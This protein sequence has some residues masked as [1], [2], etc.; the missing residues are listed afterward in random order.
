MGPPPPNKNDL[1]IPLC[2]VNKNEGRAF[3][4][5]IPTLLGLII[6]GVYMGYPCPSFCWWA[7]FGRAMPDRRGLKTYSALAG[8][9]KDFGASLLATNLEPQQL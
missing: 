4:R 2:S 7:F 6:R 1:P 8:L 3:Y 5:D 9:V